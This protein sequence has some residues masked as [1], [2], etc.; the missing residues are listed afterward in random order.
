MNFKRTLHSQIST[1]MAR[2]KSKL[3]RKERFTSRKLES[4]FQYVRNNP[5]ASISSVASMHDVNRTTLS[6]KLDGTQKPRDEA[7]V[8]QQL[9]SPDEERALA[10]WC[11]KMD[12]VGFPVIQEILHCMAQS[13][14][15]KRD[16]DNPHQLGEKWV[17]HFL[18]RNSDL[19]E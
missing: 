14:L 4:A 6:R 19:K 10:R 15:N 3:E 17:Q 9:F 8:E 16:P 18:E 2:K 7:H 5:T 13:V 12:A 11:G 1:K